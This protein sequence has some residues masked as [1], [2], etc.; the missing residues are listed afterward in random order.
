MCQF[1]FTACTTPGNYTDDIYRDVPIKN[2]RTSVTVSSPDFPQHYPQNIQCTW[3]I[4]APEGL[5]VLLSFLE[6]QLEKQSFESDCHDYV[7]VR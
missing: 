3:R 7:S 2:S 4:Q 1:F 5:Q 6:F